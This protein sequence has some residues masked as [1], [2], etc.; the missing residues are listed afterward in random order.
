MRNQSRDAA[1]YIVCPM[2]RNGTLL[3]LVSYVQNS[4]SSDMPS[5]KGSYST[6]IESITMKL[7]ELIA[8]EPTV[9]VLIFS[10]V[11]FPMNLHSNLSLWYYVKYLVMKNIINFSGM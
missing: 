8:K 1:M 4:D 7:M 3:E 5:I 2:C 11:S 9:K 10:T 6:K